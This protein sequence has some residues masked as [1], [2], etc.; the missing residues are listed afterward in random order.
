MGVVAA[1]LFFVSIL[2]HELGHAFQALRDGMR[3]DGITLWLFGGV[4]RFK[5]MFPSA[6]AEFRIAIAG[7]AVS[8]AIAAFFGL[9]I[10]LGRGIDLPA[11]V[12]GVI[13]YLWRI[14][15]LLLA[16]NLVPALPLD[17]GRVLRAW[18]WHRQESFSAATRSAAAAGKAFGFVLIAV[19]VMNF[20]AQAGGGSLWLAFL[21]WFLIQAARA[22]AS[23]VLVY[24]AL[25]NHSVGQLMTRDPVTVSPEMSISQFFDRVAEGRG[26]LFYP[27]ATDGDFK[28]LVSLEDANAVPSGERSTRK[29]SQV[30][31]DR[32]QPA[33]VTADMEVSDVLETLDQP[34]Q[35]AAVVEDG[36]LVG[37]LSP[38]DVRRA[39]RMQQVR[40][41]YAEAKTKRAGLLVW[42][43]V[44]AVYAIVAG[45]LYRPAVVVLQP[46]PTLDV[47][48]GITITGATVDDI[49][50]SY[51]LTSVVLDRP[52]ALGALSAGL[53]SDREILP[54][55]EVF[56]SGQDQSDSFDRQK[57]VFRQSRVLAA[58]AAAAGTGTDVAIEG[59]G[60]IVQDVLPAAPASGELHAGDVI[61]EVDGRQVKVADELRDAVSSRPSGT[62]FNLT[63]ERRG[64]P[65]RVEVSSARLSGMAEGS[66]GIGVIIATRDLSI[67]LPFEIEFQEQNIGGP[68]AGLIY[69]LAIADMLDPED[70]AGGKI[71]AATGTIGIDGAVGRVGGVSAKAVSVEEA[72]ADLFLVP[73]AEVDLVMIEGLEVRGVSTLGE[74]LRVLEQV[75]EA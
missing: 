34:P 41:S 53:L 74:A 39:L 65:L 62:S 9:L 40:G 7:P 35:R 42:A 75:I 17:G 10:L 2:L 58:A 31:R 37:I 29:V 22:E 1:A 3:I 12:Q 24:Q 6:G 11:A 52:N 27:V 4:A 51:L 70:H 15:V 55:S 5:G 69:A 23:S 50:G 20:L 13:D 46:G 33:V 21:G 14:N 25:R 47:G 63:V 16:F 54:M 49:N 8:A 48:H 32:S 60:V 36:R 43:V 38:S 59:T 30:V 18:L 67:D 26:H 72:G 19:G 56:P 73:Q 28:G 68:S 45:L 44:T 57:E 61:V 64:D 71:V 66:V